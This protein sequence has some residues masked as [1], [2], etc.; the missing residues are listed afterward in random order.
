MSCSST[1]VAKGTVFLMAGKIAVLP[2]L[3]LQ[4]FLIPR[5]LGP[6]SMGFY[7]FWLSV[8]FIFGSLFELGASSILSRYIPEYRVRVPAAIR[9]L[10]MKV[11]AVKIP[12]FILVLLAGV[13]LFS[14]SYLFFAIVLLAAFLYA[15][16]CSL[17]KI[18]YSFNAMGT[19]SLL[20]VA[21]IAVKFCLVLL[22]FLLFKNAGIVLALLGTSIL[23]GALVFFPLFRILPDERGPLPR[24]LRSYLSFGLWLYLA[25]L[26][27]VLIEWSAI[28]LARHNLKDLVLIGFLGF[29]LQLSLFLKHF[30]YSIAESV[31][32]S[33]V[34]SHSL[35]D[36][37][38]MIY[39]GTSWKYT[40]YFL[41][42]A[43]FFLLMMSGPIIRILVGEEFL[44]SKN[45]ILG[46]IPW[47]LFSSWSNFPRQVLL[48]HEKKVHL[49]T[50]A[51]IEFLIFIGLSWYL[52]LRVGII[53]IPAALGIGSLAGFLYISVPSIKLERFPGYLVSVIKPLV[54]G[55]PILLMGGLFIPKN[56]F[57]LA[58]TVISG[59]FLYAG[60]LVLTKGVTRDDFLRLRKAK[61]G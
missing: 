15:A 9:T 42:P 2:I 44:P 3:G 33:M 29:A 40:N 32:P 47:V 20:N 10:L 34:E 28:P 35:K 51:L 53:G 27:L 45:I 23:T 16:N 56:L 18:Y 58:V 46:L 25:Q 13:F 14:E 5:I 24:P 8:F 37:R 12:V 21:R 41:I 31:F 30:V 50:A 54:S 36:N 7:S 39:L 22:F 43:L 48:I 1:R 61:N 4:A 19:Y 52:M 17:E 49:F 26:F 11:V 59:I 38:L 6:S 57:G 60:I 55:L